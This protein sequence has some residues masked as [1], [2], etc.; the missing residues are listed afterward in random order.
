MRQTS[1]RLVDASKCPCKARANNG[2]TNGADRSWTTYTQG[3]ITGQRGTRAPRCVRGTVLRGRSR[4][5]GY[6]M[7]R[8][9][10]CDTKLLRAGKTAP[11]ADVDRCSRLWVS[12]AL[13]G[14][15]TCGGRQ[16]PPSSEFNTQGGT[17]RTRQPA[18]RQPI[19]CISQRVLGLAI[20]L[21]LFFASVIRN[22]ARARSL[23][24]IAQGPPTAPAGQAE[25]EK[26]WRG[27]CRATMGT[28]GREGQLGQNK[29]TTAEKRKH[30]GGSVSLAAPTSSS[31]GV[32]PR[33]QCGNFV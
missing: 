24:C 17:D 30:R 18:R 25:R 28:R 26:M 32:G 3:A 2:A 5:W 21:R 31:E 12:H 29:M 6:P 19:R 9:R 15:P 7:A 22:V 11:E 13:T 8:S 14:A 16:G 20:L 1:R 27:T 4:C 23:P 33:P 10:H